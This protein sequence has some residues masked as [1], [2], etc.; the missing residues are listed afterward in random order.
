MDRFLVLEDGTIYKGKGFGSD[1]H[2][3]GEVVFTTSMTGYVETLTDPSYLGQIVVFA[4]PTIGNYPW[5]EEMMESS[6]VQ[7]AGVITREGHAFLNSSSGREPLHSL[8]VTYGVPGIDG[9]DT[10]SLIMKIREKGT[11]KGVICS[12]PSAVT[13]FVDIGTQDLLKRLNVR[14]RFISGKGDMRIL[15]IDTGAKKSMIDHMSE[16]GDIQVIPYDYDFSRLS[17]DHDLLFLTNGPGDP[18]HPANSKMI[19][20]V[21]N[22]IGQK[23]VAGIC[24]GH[25][26][27]ALAS[28]ARTSKMRF[29]H[30]GV[31][32][33]VNDGLRIFVTSQNHGYAVDR[34][35]L[36]G[37]G[38]EVTLVDSND[39][40]VEGLA[41]PDLGVLSVQFHPEARPGPW[42][43]SAFFKEVRDMVMRFNAKKI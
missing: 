6:R 28:G 35:S 43:A 20:Y 41:N 7:V 9:I 34:G 16:L 30:R 15:M 5:N 31:N 24:L 11:M 39:G 3:S 23:P 37:T 4:H 22:N 25:Q 13:E 27:I 32:H 8:L 33:S 12:D 40:T 38:L 21:R 36:Q 42:D 10:R 26:V 18:N 17:A 2:V 19:E 29:G 14:S 1:L